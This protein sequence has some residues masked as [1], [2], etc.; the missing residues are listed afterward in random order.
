[1]PGAA[2]AVNPG[3]LKHQSDCM[4]RVLTINTVVRAFVGCERNAS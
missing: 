4:L 1:M 3:L 2:A